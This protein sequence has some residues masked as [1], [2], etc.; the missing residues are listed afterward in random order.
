MQCG[1]RNHIKYFCTLLH[2]NPCCTFSGSFSYVW[3][4]NFMHWSFGKYWVP[5]LWDITI[6]TFVNIFT[7]R[8]RKSLLV[9]GGCQAYS[10]RYKYS[11]IL[12]FT[13]KFEFCHWLQILSVVFLE[14]AGSLYS[15]S[16]CLPN[17]QV[18]ITIIYAHCYFKW[19]WCSLKKK[20]LVQV[21]S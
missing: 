7:D 8:I 6:S 19:K 9:L 17:S 3:S 4:C 2:Q 16:R 14:E 18:W 20:W 5:E 12:I 21:T 1:I 11:K 10:G 15:F 13:R